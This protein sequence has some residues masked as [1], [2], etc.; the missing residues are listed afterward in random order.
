MGPGLKPAYYAS[1]TSSPHTNPASI[2]QPQ[3]RARAPQLTP[4][5]PTGGA[6]SYTDNA[7]LC[8]P[9]L[10][11][12]PQEHTNHH[13]QHKPHTPSLSTRTPQTTPPLTTTITNHQ[14]FTNRS[15]KPKNRKFLFFTIYGRVVGSCFLAN[16]R[17]L[18]LGEPSSFTGNGRPARTQFVHPIGNAES[19]DQKLTPPSVCQTV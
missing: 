18:P 15:V 6:L 2:F 1:S 11:M 8:Q 9:A 10:P 19:D 4:R 17:S 3:T 16:S 13:K 14:D 7:G 12:S 5:L